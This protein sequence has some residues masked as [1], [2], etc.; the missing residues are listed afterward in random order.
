MNSAALTGSQKD[1]GS[2]ADPWGSGRGW[3]SARRLPGGLQLVRLT[4]TA[5]AKCSAVSKQRWGSEG[6]RAV[7][8]LFNRQEQER[9]CHFRQ[10]LLLLLCSRGA[11]PSP[12]PPALA[13]SSQCCGGESGLP[14]PC[15]LLLTLLI[16]VLFPLQHHRGTSRGS[17][18]LR[19]LPAVFQEAAGCSFCF[20]I[21]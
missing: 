13:L 16:P 19:S 20:W 18:K 21:P 3:Y 15:P 17:S 1:V 11:R 8:G 10:P 9:G 14:A 2:A 12:S 7:S 5:A 6:K 4:R